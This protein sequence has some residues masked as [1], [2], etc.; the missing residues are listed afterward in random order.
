MSPAH[1]MRTAKTSS[2]AVVMSGI[3]DHWHWQGARQGAGAMVEQSL[4]GD[5]VTLPAPYGA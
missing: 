3:Q 5:R 4:P 1:R 2:A